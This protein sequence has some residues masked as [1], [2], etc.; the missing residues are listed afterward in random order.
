MPARILII[1]DNRANME[2]MAYLLQAF[3][4]TVLMAWDG[5]DGLE[6]ARRERPD[7]IVC[8]IHLPKRD[9]LDVAATLKKEPTLAGIPLVAV[10]ALAMVGDRDKILSAGFEGYISKP[11]QP[12]TFV[13]DVDS[14]LKRDQPVSLRGVTPIVATTTTLPAAAPPA[15]SPKGTILVLDNSPPNLA[16]LRNT[17]TPSGYCLLEASTIKEA[18]GLARQ[19]LPDI[20][21]S[22][23]HLQRE[24]GYTFLTTVKADPALKAIPFI[25]LSSTVW[26]EQD[27]QHGL[28]LGADRFLL[29][30]IEPDVLLQEIEAFLDKR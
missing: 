22:D 16:V 11:I 13:A 21:I 15:E 25:Y 29:R 28:D 1:E 20:I 18:L 12:E 4:H 7:L 8:D 19:H 14:F 24:S 27:R 5:E 9:G 30:P 3:G 10:T 6:A 23:V 26:P 17:L 2:L